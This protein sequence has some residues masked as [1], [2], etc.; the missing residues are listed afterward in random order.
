MQSGATENNPKGHKLFFTPPGLVN[1]W[2]K[3]GQITVSPIDRRKDGILQNTC[4]I[5]MGFKSGKNV[6]VYHWLSEYKK[7]LV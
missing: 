3:P 6:Y 1:H 4:N 7:N 5:W 2:E